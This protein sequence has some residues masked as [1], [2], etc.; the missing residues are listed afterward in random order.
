MTQ[1]Q[2][3]TFIAKVR[4]VATSLLE[5][6]ELQD[7]YTAGDYGNTM[8]DTDYSGVNDGISHADLVAFF[9]TP[10]ARS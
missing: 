8:S 3:D 5:V 2:R 4:T 6:D 7:E 10:V 9:G 1:Q